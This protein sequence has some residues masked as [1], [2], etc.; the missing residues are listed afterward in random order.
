MF[1][2]LNI[3]YQVITFSQWRRKESMQS[4]NKANTSDFNEVGNAVEASDV[5]AEV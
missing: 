1:A 3:E 2:F 5:D 4:D